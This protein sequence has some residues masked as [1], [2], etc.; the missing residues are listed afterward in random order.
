MEMPM[1]AATVTACASIL[2]AILAY[3][4]NHQGETRRSLRKTQIDWVSSQLK[5]LYGPL[6]ILAET[7]EEAWSEYRRCYVLPTNAGA[8]DIPLSGP[9]EARWR[10]WVETV[11]A[12][13]AQK[14]REIIT[15]RG[16]LIIGGKMPSVVLEFCAHAA[17]YDVLL[18]DWEGAGPTKSTLIRHPGSSFLNYVR[19]SYGSLK[20]EQAV[21]LKA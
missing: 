6:L 9:E 7:N 12:P 14:M 11:F 17:T 18:A 19:E 8:A 15:A 20:V 1:I 16:D 4:L 21:L 2:I 13:T 3:W 5:D 10:T